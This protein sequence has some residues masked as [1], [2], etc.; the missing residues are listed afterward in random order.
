MYVFLD[1][2]VV[3]IIILTLWQLYPWGKSPR[4]SLDKRLG[5]QQNRSGRCGERK[6]NILKFS[7]YLLENILHLHYEDWGSNPCYFLEHRETHK[8][9][10]YD[11]ADE[12]FS[13]ESSGTNSN[14]CTLEA[15]CFHHLQ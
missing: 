13:T 11:Q 1:S 3:G 10:A 15:K 2:A 14:H 5:G 7:S 4:Y 6:I 12:Y 9:T 8:C